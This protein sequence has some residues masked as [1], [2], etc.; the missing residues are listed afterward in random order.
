MIKCTD[1]ELKALGWRWALRD[2]SGKL[3]AVTIDPQDVS[4]WDDRDPEH[5]T[6]IVPLSHVKAAEG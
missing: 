2:G 5:A 1:A 6:R 3:L 4:A